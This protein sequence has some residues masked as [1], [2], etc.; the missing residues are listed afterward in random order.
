MN[1]LTLSRLVRRLI[2]ASA[3]ASLALSFG[4][5]GTAGPDLRTF[6]APLCTGAGGLAVEGLKPGMAADYIALRMAQDFA[7]PATA[8]IISQTG[9]AC[10]TAVDP[11]ACN[12]ALMALPTS[13]GFRSCVDHACPHTLAVTQ[14]NSVSVKATA[15]EVRDFLATIDTPQ[16][17][18]LLTFASAYDISCTELDRGGVRVAADG[19]GF[20][21]LASRLTKFCAP[22]E[23]QGYELKVSKSGVITELSSRLL[24]S[25]PACIGRRPAGLDE[26]RG[27][28]CTAVG[29]Y[30]AEVARLEAAAVTAF[31]IL[32]DELALHG[33]PVQLVCAA[34][35]AMHDELRHAAVTGALA[36]RYGSQPEPPA[37]APGAPRPLFAV[38][39]D[40]AVEGCVR[41][42]F[43]AAVG[44][45]QSEHAADPM[46]AGVMTQIAEDEA[47]HAELSFQ[48]N[49]WAQTQLSRRE[50]AELRIAQRRAITELYAEAA[51]P[52][53]A[54]L[55]HFS[56]LPQPE[57]ALK[58]VRE[59]DQALWA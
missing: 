14:G 6:S 1:Q 50:L 47:R 40:N 25:S 12:S 45:F 39:L 10:A 35:A 33:A 21:V 29:A 36:A 4:C 57:Q 38:L 15:G 37:V 46:I 49:A 34:I 28:G 3:S 27:T 26:K 30:F 32:R 2:S 17:A 56:G 51:A 59:L 31:A 5:G 11:A 58:L 16:E 44:A 52:V 54:E 23:T 13:P 53:P 20:E 8:T 9:T 19:D 43:G 7:M 55:S 24:S 48:L 41:E 18:L 22:I 42:T